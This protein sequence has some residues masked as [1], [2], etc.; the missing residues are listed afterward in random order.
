MTSANSKKSTA[1]IKTEQDLINYGENLA[2]TLAP[3]ATVELLGDV[4]AGKT[5]LTKGI[6]KGLKIP[7]EITSPSFVISKCYQYRTNNKDQSLVHYDFYRLSDPGIMADDLAEN[8][9]DENTITVIE[10]ANTVANL[11][12]ENR[13]KIT[14]TLN[15]DNTRTVERSLAKWNYT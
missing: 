14:I 11:L 4:G 3:G 13:T 9:A 10:W 15:D 6:A 1:I 5:T 8:L 2:K 7:E 12:P